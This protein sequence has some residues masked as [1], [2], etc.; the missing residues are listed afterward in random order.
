MKSILQK[1]AFSI[2]VVLMTS[3]SIYAQVPQGFNF[4]AVARDA[5]GDILANQDLGVQVSLIKGNEGNNPLYQEAHSVTTNTL[6]LIQIVIGEG[7]PGDGQSFSAIDFASDDFYVKLAID[8]AG[9]TE[10]ADLGTTRLLSVPYALVAHKAIEG[11]NSGGIITELNLNTANPD[12]SFIINLEGDKQA[13]PFQ[14]F[15]KSSTDN[16]AIYGEAFSEESNSGNQR[17]VLGFAN[18]A[19]TGQHVGIFGGAVNFEATGSSRRGV[20][21]QAASKAKY[22]YGVFGLAAGDGNGESEIDPEN[23]DFGSFNLGGYFQSY[24]NLNGNTGVQGVAAG[25]AGS[26][27]NFGVIGTSRTTA[28]GSNIGVRAEAFNSS[29]INI[30]LDGAAT[31]SSKNLG[32]RIEASGGTSNVGMEVNADTAAIFNGNV[33]INGS[34]TH[35]GSGGSGGGFSDFINIDTNDPNLQDSL[36][37]VRNGLESEEEFARGLNVIGFSTGRNRPLLG[38]IREDVSNNASQYAI[39]GRADGLGGGTHI[40]V[41]GSSFNSDAANGGTRY[42]LYGQASSKSKFNIGTFAYATG[43]GSGEYVPIGDPQESQGNFGSFNQA[44]GAL[45][46]GNTNGNIAI[47][48]QVGGTEGQRINIGG[49]FRVFTEAAGGNTGVNV[50]ARGSQKENIGYFGLINGTTQNRGIILDVNGGVSNLGM[51]INADTAAVLNGLVEV[52]NDLQ[53]NGDI[54][55]TGTSSQTS[56][57]NLKENIRPLQNG[58]ETIMKLNPTTYNFRGNGEYNGLKLSTGLHYGLIAQ[59]VEEVL[60]SLVKN[61]VHTYTVPVNSGS[62]PDATQETEVE[63]TMDYKTMNYTELIPVLIKAV[64]EQQKEIEDLKKQI[65]SLKEEE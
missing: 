5:N 22:N 10:Y 63:K 34:F 27:R 36:T 52:N 2:T 20:Y 18:G 11:G 50:F 3:V 25:E 28:N 58:L 32:L 48:A 64:Q 51:I 12:S 15:S 39:S 1:I 47:D 61:N 4:Q 17:G 46:T 45:A 42:G 31:G 60:P 41:L 59:E 65:K 56:D 35:N 29:S 6:G 30:A 53:V 8:P 62:G 16:R 37:I 21:G 33:I 49:E 7:T 9:G 43:T 23:G 55:Y 54:R 14:V 57:K 44:I 40:G 13:K 26:L 19:G 24:G 38:Q